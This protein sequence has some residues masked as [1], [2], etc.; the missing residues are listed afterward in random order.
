MKYGVWCEV[1][2]GVT[3][4]RSAWLKNGGAGEPALFDTLEDAQR[5]ADQIQRRQNNTPRRTANFRYTAK[6]FA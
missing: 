6:Q 3:G 1:W 2:G 4:P 5:E